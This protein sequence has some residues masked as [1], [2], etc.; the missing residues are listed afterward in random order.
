MRLRGCGPLQAVWYF[1]SF[2]NVEIGAKRREIVRMA[3]HEAGQRDR[4]QRVTHAA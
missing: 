3:K 4:S 1:L 2:K